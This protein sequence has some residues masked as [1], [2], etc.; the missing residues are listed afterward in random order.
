MLRFTLIMSMCF[1]YM[2]HTYYATPFTATIFPII[3]VLVYIVVVLKMDKRARKFTLTL[4]IVGIVVHFMNGNRGF[5]LFEG[6]TQNL[7]LLAILILAPLISIPLKREGIIDTVVIGLTKNQNDERKAFYSLSSFMFLLAPILNMGAIRIVHGFINNIGLQPKMLSRAYYTGFTPAVLWSPF[8]ASVGIVLYTLEMTYMSY[9]IV[10]VLFAIIQLVTAVLLLRPKEVFQE[11]KSESSE[12]DETDMNSKKNIFLLIG[13]VLCLL[14]LLISM[15]AILK[16]PMLLLVSFLCLFVPIFWF[17]IRNKWSVVQEEYG[18]YKSNVLQGSK[19]EITLFLSAGLFG[20]AIANTPLI[21]ILGTV[22]E[23]S[24]QESLAVL[25]LFILLFVTSMAM[26]GVHQIISIPLV[27]MTL[28]ESG[29]AFNPLPIAFMC[30]F[31][32]ML[33]AAISPL[34]AMNIIISQN[35]RENGITVAY[36]WNGI[37]FLV[38]TCIAF[39]YIYIIDLF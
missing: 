27:L 33:S 31:S 3:S 17:L 23:W 15:E 30:I 22:I 6:I 5:E 4:F 18:L 8:Y 20:N 14:F 34:N 38:I 24:F 29:V 1:I 26:I 36:R 28:I 7:P 25:F 35:V 39:I 32:W 19:M 9:I 13:F 21:K 10:G 11:S 2:V 16:K 12:P 37:Y